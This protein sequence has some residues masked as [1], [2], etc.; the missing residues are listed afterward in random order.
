MKTSV[1]PTLGVKVELTGDYV[2]FHISAYK[3]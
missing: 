2:M 1:N 3:R